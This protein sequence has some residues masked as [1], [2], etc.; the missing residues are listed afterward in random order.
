MQKMMSYRHPYNVG[1]NTL[2]NNFK[3]KTKKNVNK[4]FIKLI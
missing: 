3:V 4:Y 1:G 2:Y